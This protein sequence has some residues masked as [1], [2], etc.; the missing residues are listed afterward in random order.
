MSRGS[1]SLPAAPAERRL[2]PTTVRASC[3]E[4][5][6]DNRAAYAK[7]SAGPGTEMRGDGTFS[8]SDF[9]YDPEG[10]AYV[11]PGGK[12]RRN[13]TA[14]YPSRHGLRKEGTATPCA[15]KPKCCPNMPARKI[16]RSVH[17][18]ARE[19]ARNRQD[20]GLGRLTSAAKEGQDAPCPSDH[21]VTYLAAAKWFRHSSGRRDRRC[22]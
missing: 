21:A 7:R 13:T 2:T 10:N 12:E 6:G 22:V 17:E 9:A 11:C 19:G 15:L 1:D 20:R 16:A 8:R 4:R 5:S 3:F 14:R 18:A